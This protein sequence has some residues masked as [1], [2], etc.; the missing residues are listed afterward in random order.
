[1]WQYSRLCFVIISCFIT[2]KNF[3]LVPRWTPWRKLLQAIVL[4]TI[5]RQIRDNI[6][7]YMSSFIYRLMKSESR[8][9]LSSLAPGHWVEP[10]QSFHWLMYMYVDTAN[11]SNMIPWHYKNLRAA[12]EFHYFLSFTPWLIYFQ[13]WTWQ[14]PVA[15]TNHIHHPHGRPTPVI[16]KSHFLLPGLY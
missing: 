14:L 13:H 5:S 6:Y 2:G 8:Q 10:I 12:E 7:I 4:R 1:M 11:W 9:L 15:I 16:W 3:L